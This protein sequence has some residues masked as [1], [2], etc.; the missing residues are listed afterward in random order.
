[1]SC[2]ASDAV[3]QMQESWNS[4]RDFALAPGPEIIPGYRLDIIV[5]PDGQ[6][7]SIAL[8]DQKEGAS[9]FSLFSD[10]TGIIYLGAPLQ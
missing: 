6:S 4:R 3:K 8:H 5:S 2:Y 7:Y 1:M 9:L 10:Q